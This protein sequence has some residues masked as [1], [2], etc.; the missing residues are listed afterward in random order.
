MSLLDTLTGTAKNVAVV[1]EE[2]KSGKP[3]QKGKRFKYMNSTKKEVLEKY[4]KV[5]Q[6]IKISEVKGAPI[7]IPRAS[8]LKRIEEIY[9]E[10]F[11]RLL[12]S[13]TTRALGLAQIV[14]DVIKKAIKKS[15]NYFIQSLTNFMY[16]C[17]KYGDYKEISQFL[18]FV[19]KGGKD[20]SLLF[21][22]YNRQNFKI[23][24]YNSFFNHKKS[25]V[26]PLLIDISYTQALDIIEQAY[27]YDDLVAFDLKKHIKTKVKP[28][29][30]IKFYDFLLALLEPTVGYRDLELMN[31]LIA[32]YNV[33]KPEFLMDEATLVQTMTMGKK[34]GSGGMGGTGGTG[35]MGGTGGTG[36][37]FG[38]GGL[39][40]G[41][42][43]G[44]GGMGGGLH[45]IEEEDMGKAWD[46]DDGADVDDEVNVNAMAVPG[47]H[48]VAGF[49]DESIYLEDNRVIQKYKNKI[50]AE[51]VELQKQIKDVMK[52]IVRLFIKK[53]KKENK[54]ESLNPIREEQIYDRVYKKV[55]NL[56]TVIF[57]ADRK[58]YFHLLRVAGQN[59]AAA[60]LWTNMSKQY[61]YM[62]ELNSFSKTV[63]ADFIRTWLDNPLVNKNILFFLSYE[64]GCPNEIVDEALNIETVVLVETVRA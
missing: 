1:D 25:A 38:E 43:M 18:I 3:W 35:G 29:T 61:Q 52:N 62:M 5:F 21:Y 28:K 58:K 15:R 60:D 41:G 9:N 11:H 56:T 54:C 30:R 16:S 23:L 57:Y 59:K 48:G 46:N 13:R 45:G 51:E 49:E 2:K 39:G 10:Q 31:Y 42:G 50:K 24:T 40:G 4:P 26:N 36:G 17:D 37:D 27:Y 12:K 20:L 64:Y 32:L 44:R 33:K 7:L 63:A 8:I 47:G 6:G 19:Q 53:F 34:G 14:H 22:I 55:F